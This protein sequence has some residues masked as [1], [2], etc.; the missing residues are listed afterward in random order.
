MINKLWVEYYR[1]TKIT[2]YVFQNELHKVQTKKWI[3]EKEI[4]HLLFWGSP[5]TGKTSLANVLINE[6]EIDNNDILYVNASQDN[7]V[8]FIRDKIS[9]FS[10][11]MPWGE[12]KIIFLDEADYLSPNAQ[13]I[14]RGMMERYNEVRFIL[15]ANYGNRIIPAIKSRCQIFH[16]NKPEKVDFTEKLAKILIDQNIKFEL[17]ILDF[18]VR[19][20]YP[21]L[22]KG[23]NLLQQNSI[24]G[25]LNINKEAETTDWMLKVVEF[26]Q[27][28]EIRKARELICKS[29]TPEDYEGLYTFLYRNLDF[30]GKTPEQQDE[31]IIIIRNGMVKHTQCADSE[32]NLSATLVELMNVNK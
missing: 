10:E 6:L 31:A 26:F 29:A 14:L 27:D 32:L 25:I 20:I 5:G 3:N 15:T 7:G 4:P 17:D 9:S 19:T 22:R 2:E 18:Y 30:F 21:D 13:S 12:F 1:P 11:I 23:I 28:G 8:D 16:L 24:N